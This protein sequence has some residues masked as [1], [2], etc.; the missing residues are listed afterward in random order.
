MWWCFSSRWRLRPW[1]CAATGGCRLPGTRLIT[2][3]TGLAEDLLDELCGSAGTIDE[4]AR[5]PVLE[6]K[7]K[8]RRGGR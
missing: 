1:W 5:Q 7:V 6:G 3:A 2:A 4:I 8:G